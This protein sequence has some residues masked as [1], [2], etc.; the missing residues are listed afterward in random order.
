[1]S[2]AFLYFKIWDTR[3]Q[4]FQF[5]RLL[6]VCRFPRQ[7][8]V[9]FYEVHFSLLSVQLVFYDFY[10]TWDG[11][12]LWVWC[13]LGQLSFSLQTSRYLI[14]SWTS[15]DGAVLLSRLQMTC[16]LILAYLYV[17]TFVLCLCMGHFVPMILSSF[18]GSHLKH[19]QAS[20]IFCFQSG[21]GWHAKHSYYIAEPHGSTV[22]EEV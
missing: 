9:W 1:M 14:T 12:M 19:H 7:T 13:P 20:M 5:S 18:E 15:E 11:L 2:A 8:S 22:H 4:Y 6:P 21:C 17:Y 16:K 3:E 10:T